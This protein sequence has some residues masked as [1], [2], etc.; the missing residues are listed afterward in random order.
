[1]MQA[2]TKQARRWP[3]WMVALLLVGVGVMLALWVQ[4]GAPGWKLMVG[5]A[6]ATALVGLGLAG[7]ASKRGP[8]VQ[9]LGVIG[10]VGLAVVGAW[11]LLATLAGWLAG[12]LW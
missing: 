1:M 3:G 2:N 8:A 11:W 9:G 10:V 6:G 12:L 7:A 5:L 4:E